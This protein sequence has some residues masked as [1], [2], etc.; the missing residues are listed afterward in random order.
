MSKCTFVWLSG[1]CSLCELF[2]GIEALSAE[3]NERRN[4]E[5]TRTTK[6][7]ERGNCEQWSNGQT[8]CKQATL[9]KRPQA[10]NDFEPNRNCAFIFKKINY[11]PNHSQ[12][13]SEKTKIDHIFALK[14][15]CLTFRRTIGITW[16][17][18]THLCF[19]FDE[20]SFH[21][22]IISIYIYIKGGSSCKQAAILGHNISRT[23]L[24]SGFGHPY[25][26][27]T[28]GRA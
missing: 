2:S 15:Q 7:L 28:A 24:C 19:Y 26:D 14:A 22:L 4:P 17:K 5:P 12:G 21:S 9:K 8:E 16:N 1:C 20:F 11:L 27:I 10:F 6:R 13:N 23:R 18:N 25:S 3:V